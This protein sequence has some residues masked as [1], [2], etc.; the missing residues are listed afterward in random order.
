M[1]NKDNKVQLGGTILVWLCLLAVIGALVGG[2]VYL[3]K[4]INNIEDTA[5]KNIGSTDSTTSQSTSSASATTSTGEVTTTPTLTVSKAALSITVKDGSFPSDSFV[6][7]LGGVGASA[8]D[9]Q[10]KLIITSDDAELD[11]WLKI[12]CTRSGSDVQLASPYAFASGETVH[13]QPL[14]VPT[15]QQEGWYKISLLIKSAAFSLEKYVD[16]NIYAAA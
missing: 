12:W 5:T 15:V 16:I 9:E 7:A 4:S 11:S 14:K 13:L 3:A 1:D 2:S 6:A 8:T 10:K